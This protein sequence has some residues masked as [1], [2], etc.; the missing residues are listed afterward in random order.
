MSMA[1]KINHH[2]LQSVKVKGPVFTFLPTQFWSVEICLWECQSCDCLSLCKKQYVR[3][4]FVLTLAVSHLFDST[5]FW[6]GLQVIAAG[7]N[8]ETWQWHTTLVLCTSGSGFI[9]STH[10]NSCMWCYSDES[11]CNL[12]IYVMWSW[13]FALFPVY[14]GAPMLSSSDHLQ[15]FTGQVQM[16]LMLKWFLI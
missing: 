9:S 16:V 4:R 12:H 15:Q 5:H 6:P 7:N 14:V 1:S 11:W 10:W 8:L 13:W 3:P 2:R